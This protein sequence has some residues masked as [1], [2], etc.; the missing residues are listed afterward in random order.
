MQDVEKDI[1]RRNL[2]QSMPH[3]RNIR[4]HY[5]REEYL[6][7]MR[8]WNEKRLIVQLRANLGY[9]RTNETKCEFGILKKFY[10][11]DHN[12]IC[13]ICNENVENNY[14]ALFECKS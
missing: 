14:H 3:Y 1:A 4:T 6:N 13:K 12:D 11:A 9:I 5:R 8:D 7:N 10:K 2:S